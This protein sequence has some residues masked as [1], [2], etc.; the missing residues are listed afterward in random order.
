MVLLPLHGYRLG[1]RYM[2][3]LLRRDSDDPTQ[4]H[5]EWFAGNV[6]SRKDTEEPISLLDK[7]FEVTPRA[8]WNSDTFKLV[9]LLAEKSLNS[10]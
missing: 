10:Y 7:V 4:L 9:S 1:H 6:Y 3:K 5:V 2:A 8:I